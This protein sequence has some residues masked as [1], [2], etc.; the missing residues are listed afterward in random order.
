VQ[1]VVVIQGT[2]P[3][4]MESLK[5]RGQPPPPLLG[6][7]TLKPLSILR[8]G[9]RQHSFQ[10]GNTLLAKQTQAMSALR[11]TPKC[12]VRL[13]GRP[14]PRRDQRAARNSQWVDE[15]IG[16]GRHGGKG[17]RGGAALVIAW[18][19]MHCQ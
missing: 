13:W 5:K 10:P 12:A 7:P 11:Q 19:R 9:F 14:S 3:K 6:I 15:R 18:W 16:V 2:R 4:T 17:G 8:Q 1:N